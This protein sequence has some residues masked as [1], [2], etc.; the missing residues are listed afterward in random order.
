MYKKL[1]IF[2]AVLIPVLFYFSYSKE[3]EKVEDTLVVGTNTDFPPFSFQ[4]DGEIKGFDIDIAR[5][6]CRLLDKKMVLK[7]MPF[8]ALIPDLLLGNIDFI[9]AG[10]SYTPERAE[11][12]LFTKPHLKNDPLV[13]LTLKSSQFPPDGDLGALKGKTIIVNEGYTADLYL[14]DKPGL[15]LLRLALPADAFVALKNGRGFAFVTAQ[16]TLKTFLDKQEGVEFQV[17]VIPGTIENYALV[18]SKKNPALAREIQIALD[19][20]QENGTIDQLKK[21]WNFE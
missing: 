10:M 3:T 5:E 2:L 20:M 12:V 17:N 11:R 14:S 19:T 21:K 4:V 8:E 6:V 16:S 13:I 7:D 15:N 1:A 9:A 18:V